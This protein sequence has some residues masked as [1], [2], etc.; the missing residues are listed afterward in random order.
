[1]TFGVPANRAP[2]NPWLRR[3]TSPWA[4]VVTLMVF[5]AVMIASLRDKSP[6]MDELGH[7]TAGYSYWKFNDYRIDPENGNLAKRWIALP[8]LL[9]RYEFPGTDAGWWLRPDGWFL[10]DEWFYRMGNDS[11]AML[12]RG[13]AMSGLIAVALGA[14]VWAWSARL[15][16]KVGGMIS[17]LIYVLNPAILANGA[18]MTSDMAAALFFVLSAGCWWRML[19]RLSPLNVLI[20]ALATSAL[21][22][23]K[24]S[25]VVIGPVALTL[26]AIRL[27]EGSPLPVIR[28]WQ[29]TRRS[30]QALGFVTAAVV[31]CV[32]IGA[33]VWA[34]FGF[35][36][37]AFAREP[38]ARG[39][40]YLPWEWVLNQP[41]PVGL[42]QK[43]QLAPG[44]E[45]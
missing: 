5:Y 32:I 33:V 29:L 10:A 43:L 3:L 20:S 36:Y 8:L 18:L 12:A 35:R 16:G 37:S 4:A 11:S 17:L 40:F 42:L 13:R 24:M 19:Q 41:E 28:S 34:S 9:G 2:T 15:F 31:H 30:Y 6:T 39:R 22:V 1:M 44:Q 21:F 23:A 38:A 27:W 25:A 26:C 45:R 7:A 14:L